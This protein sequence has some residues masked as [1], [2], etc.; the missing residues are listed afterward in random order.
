MTTKDKLLERFRRLPND[1]TFDELTRLLESFGFE[2]ENKGR[3]SGSRVLF[4]NRD[5]G[6]IMLHRP[7]PA[8]VVRVYAMKQV[9]ERLIFVGLIEEYEHDE[10]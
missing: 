7:H 6:I 5:Y 3:T 9:L 4:R 10:L 2:K 8:N 1:F